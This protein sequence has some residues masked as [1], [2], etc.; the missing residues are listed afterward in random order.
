MRYLFA[1]DRMAKMVGFSAMAFLASTSIFVFSQWF[2][3]VQ[4]LAGLAG[5]VWWISLAILL[6]CP[7]AGSVVFN[8]VWQRRRQLLEQLEMTS[9]FRPKSWKDLW[10]QSKDNKQ[11]VPVTVLDTSRFVAGGQTWHWDDFTKSCFVFG[12][13]G[14]GKTVCVLNALLDGLLSSSATCSNPAGGLILDPKGDF[15]GK[16]RNVMRRH[17]REESLIVIDPANPN[18]SARWNPLDS[19]DDELELASRFAATLEALGM[20]Q[21]DTSFWIDSAKKFLRHAIKLV[22]LTNPAGQPPNLADVG[23]LATSGHALSE[24]VSRLDLTSNECDQCLTY[25]AN[26]WTELASE[27][28]TSIMSYL[29]NMIDP[30]LMEPYATLFSG[31]STMQ[32]G[33]MINNGIVLYVDMPIADR[34]AMARAVGTFIKLEYFRE[35]LKRPDKP[36]PT[37]FLCDEFQ[38]FFTTAHGKGDSDFLERSRQ[39]NHANVLAS[40]NL[41]ALLKQ[42][43]KEEPVLNLLGNCAIKLFLRNTDSKTNQ[44]GSQLFGQQ[45]ISMGSSHAGG[46]VGFGRMQIAGA[47]DSVSTQDQYDSVVRP[48][49]FTELAIPSRVHDVAYCEAILHNAAVAEMETGA[50]TLNWPVHPI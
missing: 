39:S 24:R 11:Q 38:V 14:S 15:R 20:K 23:E 25:F 30:F 50:S 18:I 13:S 22:R 35:V 3:G 8:D 29:T 28:R 17:N 45:L 34:E 10:D 41:P 6:L 32:I 42:S 21:Q 36:R 9:W 31:T 49:R 16:V 46:S 27:T 33:D 5:W 19:P 7:F 44:Y 37:F 48:E 1:V 12:Q 47:G 40:Q 43:N 4:A 2:Y 26:E